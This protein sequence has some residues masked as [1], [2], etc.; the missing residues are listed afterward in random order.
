[1][2]RVSTVITDNLGAL[3]TEIRQTG[4]LGTLLTKAA[5]GNRLTPEEKRKVRSQ[6]I[7]L[8]KAVPAL[9]IFAAP[10]GTIL[11]PILAK[12]LPFNFLPSAW[13]KVAGPR[14]SPS[15]P[16][17]APPPRGGRAGPRRKSRSREE[18]PRRA[19][20]ARRLK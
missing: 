9:A 16:A 11:L 1:M 13:D 14:P 7:D 12:I 8:A 10:G 5:A 19:Q 4:E 18:L 17:K 2:E 3:A 20:R 15:P 6:L